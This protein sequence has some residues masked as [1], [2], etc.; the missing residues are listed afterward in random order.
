MATKKEKALPTLP[1]GYKAWGGIAWGSRVE[2]LLEIS[3]WN[4]K[5]KNAITADGNIQLIRL[6]RAAQNDEKIKVILIHGG[7]F[8]GSGNDLS[9][10]AASASMDPEERQDL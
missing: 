10:L 9:L 8:Y 5:R 3:F 4:V 2:G 6:I 1:E 7:L